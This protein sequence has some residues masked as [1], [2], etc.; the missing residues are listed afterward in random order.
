MISSS[1]PTGQQ[2]G[3]LLPGL[4]QQQDVLQ[5]GG[6]STG[7]WSLGAGGRGLG[8]VPVMSRP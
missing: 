4:L 5:E 6:V 1:S 7:G 2:G 8:A 3:A